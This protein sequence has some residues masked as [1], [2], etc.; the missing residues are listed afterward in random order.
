MVVTFVFFAVYQ[1]ALVLLPYYAARS[2]YR[3]LAAGGVTAAFMA[4]AVI[5]PVLGRGLL[6]H[7]LL[8]QAVVGSL[9]VHAAG[10]VAVGAGGGIA[11][12][13]AT[14]VVRGVTFGILA[15]ALPV[16]LVGSVPAG[17]RDAQL[18]IWGM[19][20]TLPWA[21]APTLAVWAAHHASLLTVM[22][23][24]GGITLGVAWAVARA[25]SG[26]RW[27]TTREPPIA[28]PIPRAT[29]AAWTDLA[30]PSA[31]FLAASGTYGA[32]V[33]FAPVYLADAQ[34]V[35]TNVAFLLA[36][37][38]AMPVGRLA[39]G[40]GARQPRIIVALPAALTLTIAGLA[41]ILVSTAGYA[42]AVAGA[43]CGLGFGIVCTICHIILLARAGSERPE[44]GSAAFSLVFNAGMGAG[45]LAMG[46]LAELA[47][48]RTGFLIWALLSTAALP[49]SLGVARST[50]PPG[51]HAGAWNGR[52]GD[53]SATNASPPA[54]GTASPS[55]ALADLSK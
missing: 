45:G 14:S 1:L 2:G 9:A 50:A 54:T 15:A 28:E 16:A 7:G 46:A 40:A 38:I 51:R 35:G 44:N 27:Q 33:S 41:T 47:G 10:T 26:G 31:V 55:D 37:G 24:A 3:E 25:A 13:L 11:V 53:S 34:T 17:D 12:L 22:S 48:L 36:M 30:A 19:V 5:G 21:F 42:V 29:G 49:L 23:I 4:G 32:V 6:A 20:S 18:G 8:S 39:G 52:T 43:A